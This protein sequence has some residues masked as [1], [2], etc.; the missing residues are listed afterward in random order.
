MKKKA[1]ILEKYI[2]V[3]EELKIKEEE[4]NK[5]FQIVIFASEANLL[6]NLLQDQ[7]RDLKIFI[8]I[9][10]WMLND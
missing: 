10:D 3:K 4:Y 9:L 7:I 2:K 5:L 6:Q 8:K 1:D